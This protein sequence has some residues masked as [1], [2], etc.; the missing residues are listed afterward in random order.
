M[1]QDAPFLVAS[2]VTPPRYILPGSTYMLTRR[3]TQRQFLLQPS[4]AVNGALEHL[5]AY[6]AAKY[7]IRVHACCVLSNHYHLIVHD[8]LGNI[9]SFQQLFN[10][11]V[12][13]SLNAH[14]GRWEN[15]WSSEEPS[16]VR[17]TR[18]E[19]VFDKMLY[20]ICNP[21]SSFLVEDS[22][23]WPGLCSRPEHIGAG[24]HATERP[25]FFFRD[26]GPVPR[27]AE[28]RLETPRGW[29]REA[30]GHF[31]R[32]VKDRQAEIRDGV[33]ASG[34]SFVGLRRIRR[35]TFEGRPR[36]IERRRK[37][38]PHIA[39]KCPK[40]RVR[41][42]ARWKRFV[43]EYREA[44]GEFVRGA[45]DVLFPAGTYLMKELFGV[46]C[47]PAPEPAAPT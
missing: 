19:D 25:G 23:L 46:R 12:A 7:G 34:R 33:K 11:L 26:G 18:S 22:K 10:S 8:P 40:L 35:Q 42:I 36:T 45:R 15:F 27:T 24:A 14:Y 43:A 31:E 29:D 2:D 20:T 32:A 44:L 13:R 41:E 5:L 47:A 21:V 9:S 37:R 39:C 1:S 4:E 3:C 30:L 6:A 17:L 28:L 38:T 16:V